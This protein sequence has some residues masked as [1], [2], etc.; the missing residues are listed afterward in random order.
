MEIDINNN[1]AFYPNLSDE[2]LSTLINV[3]ASICTSLFGKNKFKEPIDAL[4]FGYFIG[5]FTSKKVWNISQKDVS[6]LM[7]K[8]YATS[9]K[10]TELDALLL[11][12]TLEFC[13]Y[14]EQMNNNGKK[15][16]EKVNKV[17]NINQAPYE[18]NKNSFNII[19]DKPNMFDDNQTKAKCAICLDDYDILDELNYGLSCGCIIHSK[20][21]D[22]Y[23]ITSVKDNKIPIKCPYCNLSIVNPNYVIEALQ[24]SNEEDLISK[25]EQY[26]LNYY[27]LN[28][29]EDISCC[30]T[31]GCSYM[32]YYEK[33]DTFFK[34]PICNKEYCMKCKSD[35]HEKIS[36][37]ENQKLR[38][39]NELDKEFYK[40]VK[41][42]M[43]KQ[44]PFCKMWV[45]KTVGCNHMR[46]RCGKD[47]C[48]LCGKPMDMNKGHSC[49]KRPLPRVRPIRRRL[50]PNNIPNF[51]N[52][53]RK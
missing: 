46:C 22:Q 32:F 42:A 51:M 30:P 13:N 33:D 41:G 2:I 34:C 39:V 52:Y 20:C 15:I 37:E 49:K 8:Y 18:D 19:E 5:Y 35:W 28:H 7:E 26:E 17:V 38:N 27:A 44:C 9:K 12:V 45:E 47:F 10:N 14:F 36:C 25:Y 21:F 23:V 53:K 43:Y 40:Y 4:V 16:E 1:D 6:L 29:N 48:Y 50:G 11:N 31:P 3:K 24:T